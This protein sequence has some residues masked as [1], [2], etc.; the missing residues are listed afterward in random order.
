[1]C[2]IQPQVTKTNIWGL[3]LFCRVWK[4][5]EEQQYPTELSARM[6]TFY[7]LCCPIRQLLAITG[8]Y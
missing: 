6:E 7:Y 1:M 4:Q 2:L 3:I 8:S 5:G